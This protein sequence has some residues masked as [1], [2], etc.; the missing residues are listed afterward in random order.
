MNS[1]M[2]VNPVV[3]RVMSPT[4]PPVDVD[5]SGKLGRLDIAVELGVIIP[6]DYLFGFSVKHNVREVLPKCGGDRPAG[7]RTTLSK[8]L[9]KLT[10]FPVPSSQTS[11]M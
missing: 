1:S 4:A 10:M 3:A 9:Q 8:G 7:T 2:I 6:R 11:P 5:G